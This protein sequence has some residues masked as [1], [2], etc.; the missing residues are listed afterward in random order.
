M[1]SDESAA[2]RRLL[3]VFPHPDD[4]SYGCAGLLSRLG[5]QPDA[6]A[7]LL[8]LTRGE[9]SS[10]GRERGLSPT[11][12]GALRTERLERVREILGLE[13]LDVRDL[14]DGGLARLAMAEVAAVVLEAV[15]AFRP[16]VVVAHC[17]RGVNGH[18]DH[19]ATHWAVRR[20][21]EERP[22][23]RVAQVAYRNEICR[24]LAPRLLFPTK[25]EHIDV[26]VHLDDDETAAKEACLRI[27]DGIV[28]LYPDRVE[29]GGTDHGRLVLRP[30]TEEFDLLGERFESPVEDVFAGL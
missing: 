29:A 5:R 6:S 17:A 15:D 8:C 9:A 2:R 3:A 13:L 24:R 22:G 7:G 18:L 27:H 30:R 28:T 20:A 19:V 25:D 21:L 4:E 12:V 23:I 26:T 11:E 1:S 14:P 10:M 16:H